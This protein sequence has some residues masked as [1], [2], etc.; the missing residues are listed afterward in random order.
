PMMLLELFLN[1]IIEVFSARRNSIRIFY[2]DSRVEQAANF[3]DYFKLIILLF[4]VA[5]HVAFCFDTPFG[6]YLVGHHRYLIQNISS[7]FS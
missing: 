4:A 1:P 3:I 2:R 7:F 6:I 5:G